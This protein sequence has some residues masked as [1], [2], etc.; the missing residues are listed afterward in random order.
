MIYGQYFHPEVSY[1]WIAHTNSVVGFEWHDVSSLPVL[2][3][4]T[5]Q[6]LKTPQIR[7]IPTVK[8]S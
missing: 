5:K 7:V 8:L 4:F 3:R 6:P 1:I 2:F